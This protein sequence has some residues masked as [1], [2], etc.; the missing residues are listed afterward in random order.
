MQTP[1]WIRADGTA[2]RMSAMQTSHVYNALRYIQQG[3][4]NLGP[5]TRHGCSGFTNGEWER[6]FQAELVLR[7]RMTGKAN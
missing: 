5:L 6:L 7:A 1:Q 2:I 3:T 4:G